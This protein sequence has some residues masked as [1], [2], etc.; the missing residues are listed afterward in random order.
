MV[1]LAVV[2]VLA[3]GVT[4]AL[5]AVS[6]V[7]VVMATLLRPG[8]HGRHVV[9]RHLGAVAETL[10]AH[11]AGGPEVRLVQ[12]L[13]AAQAGVAPLLQVPA[14]AAAAAAA[15]TQ[16]FPRPLVVLVEAVAV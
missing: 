8:V 11:G 5:V 12:G 13:R 10:V 16:V 2:V 14:A 6:V 15:F 3:V 7:V 1:I 9:H 4:C